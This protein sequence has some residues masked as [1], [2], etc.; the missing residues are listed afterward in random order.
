MTPRGRR[1]AGS[2]DARE[3]ILAVARTAFARDGYSTSLRGIARD[4]GVDPALVHHYFPGRAQLFTAA[5]LASPEGQE[6]DAAA[7][8]DGVR[9]LPDSKQGEALVRLFVIQWDDLGGERFA[10]VVRAALG[11]E[12]IMARIRAMLLAG[13]VT[14]VVARAAPAQ[15]DL[16]AQLVVSQLVGLGV[17]RW[18]ARLDAVRTADAEVLAAAVGPT[19]QRYMTGDLAG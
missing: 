6:L 17:A 8:I 3:A 5:I 9:N 1:P 18:V 7:L 16:R 11:D 2:P 12:A 15:A 4:A 19:V 13:L 10:A 14:P